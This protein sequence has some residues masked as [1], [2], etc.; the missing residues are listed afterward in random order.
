MNRMKSECDWA[1]W[2]QVRKG[3]LALNL[4]TEELRK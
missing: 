1:A 4:F 2:A 3:L